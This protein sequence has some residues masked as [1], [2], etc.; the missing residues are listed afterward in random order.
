MK[1]EF[2]DNF[3]FRPRIEAAIN[4]KTK[5]KIHIADI[6]SA[7]S[8]RIECPSKFLPVFA[9]LYIVRIFDFTGFHCI[10]HTVITFYMYFASSIA[11]RHAVGLFGMSC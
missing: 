3:V 11:N 9:I 6:E 2:S 10:A 1:N 4:T 7:N 8:P 5:I